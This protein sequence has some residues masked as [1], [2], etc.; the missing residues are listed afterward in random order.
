MRMSFRYL[1]KHPEI[2]SLAIDLRDNG[3]GSVS[4]GNA[5]LTYLVPKAFTFRFGRKANLLPINPGLKMGPGIRITPVSFFLYP[6]SWVKDRKWTHWFIKMPKHKNRFKGQ[7][8][9]ITNGRSFSMSVVTSSY[10]KYKANAT[11][12]GEETGGTQC[13]SNAM[14]SGK[15]VLPTSGAQLTIPLYRIDHTIPVPDTKRGLMP[16]YPVQYTI[17]DLMQG[18]DLEMEKIRSLMRQDS[19]ATR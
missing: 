17:L 14:L 1:H 12:I 3:G 11:L 4:K 7:L 10:L 15:V 19:S 6:V 2:N 13:G 16:D 18:R 8:Y 9:V 5:M